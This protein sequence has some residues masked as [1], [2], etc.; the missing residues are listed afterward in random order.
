[1]RIYRSIE[2]NV[3]QYRTSLDSTGPNRT[4][5]DLYRIIKDYTRLY[6]PL[7]DDRVASKIVRTIEDFIG[8]YMNLQ[9]YTGQNKIIYD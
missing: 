3:G 1:M 8:L 4:I 9:D 6:R 7:Q 2:E 5:Q